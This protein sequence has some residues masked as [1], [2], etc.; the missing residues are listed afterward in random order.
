[1]E[2]RALWLSIA[3]VG[4]RRGRSFPRR[5]FR[6]SPRTRSFHG[7]K[8][9]LQ[10]GPGGAKLFTEASRAARTGCP[11]SRPFATHYPPNSRATEGPSRHQ[12]WS[13]SDLVN[14]LT[15]LRACYPPVELR[16]DTPGTAQPLTKHVQCDSLQSGPGWQGT[17][18]NSIN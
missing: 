9:I 16:A 3:N 12:R 15:A 14:A 10:R 11:P 5:Q 7:R 13:R 17:E 6:S 2:G 8:I 1:M 4:R 18:C